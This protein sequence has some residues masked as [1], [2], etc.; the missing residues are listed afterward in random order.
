MIKTIKKLLG[1][2]TFLRNLRRL[3][4]NNLSMLY[5]E[6]DLTTDYYQKVKKTDNK[7]L[8]HQIGSLTN[9]KQIINYIND[10]NLEG[11]IIEF[12]CWKGFSLLWI[13]WLC[14]RVGMF[15]KKII[16]LDGFRG[17]PNSE[18][19]FKIGNFSDT[20]LEECKNNLYHSNDLYAISKKNI[21][22]AEFLF[23]Q[24]KE[25]QEYLNSLNVRKLCFIH[26]DCDIS[27]SALE[28]F[29]IL[30]NGDLMADKCFILFDDYA[31]MDSYKKTIDDI[32]NR[33]KSTWEI[34]VH[35]QTKLTKNFYI[36]KKNQHGL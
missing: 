22:I 8:E 29:D 16:G 5:K 21:N 3:N 23:H 11:D 15:G 27:S 4:K 20:S 26:I 33:L 19:I 28:I 17:L 18:G 1:K 25:I 13:S 24:K 10:N 30:T 12:G 14:E 2:N 36:T 6:N 35:S 32:M 7:E 31:C 9:Y 34:T